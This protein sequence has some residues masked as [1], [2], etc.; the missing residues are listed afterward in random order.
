MKTCSKYSTS[1]ITI[2]FAM[3]LSNYAFAQNDSLI[4]DYSS[5]KRKFKLNALVVGRYTASLN[6]DTNYLGQHYTEE[7]EGLVNNSFEMKYVR[8]STTFLINDRISTSILV[9]LAEFKNEQVRGKVLE[10][11]FVS[12]RHNSYF[13]VM[14]GQFRPFFGL[15]D[16]HPFQ[17]ESSYA[18]SRQYSLFSRNGWQSFQIGAAAF[19][20]LESKILSYYLTVY[21][22]NNK[23]ING[24]NDSS[25]NFTL[26]LEYMPVPVLKIG[27]N[28]GKGN[29]KGQEA[30]AYGID[31][32]FQQ[33]LGNRFDLDVNAEYKKG[34]NFEAFRS[35]EEPLP[36]LDNYRI[37]GFYFL[38]RL[39]YQL[40]APRLRAL[41]LSFRQ[42]Y[43]DRNISVEND[44]LMTYVPMLSLVF[45]GNY[46]AKLSLVGVINDYKRNLPDTPQYDSS[47]MLIQFQATY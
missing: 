33:P 30:N 13:N 6:S 36:N 17:L 16:M 38:Y 1:I 7:D 42:E 32:Q 5:Y 22:G 31:G 27:L 10:N 4:D 45:A 46:D 15:E 23:N 44:E 29:Y 18:W 40:H 37:K 2:I 21:N 20:S 8:L 24:D 43:L 35:S 19:G 41:E 3:L 34:T 25:K 26:R 39:R 47:K 12:Y 28:A 11:A 14:L 9:N